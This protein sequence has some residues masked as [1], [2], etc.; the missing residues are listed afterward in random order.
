MGTT[1]I[2]R[3]TPDDSVADL[4]ALL[5]R[6]YAALAGMGLRFVATWQDETITVKRIARGECFVAEVDGRIVGTI[7]FLPSSVTKG[8]PFYDRPDVAGFQQFA[9]EPNFQKSGIGRAL[10][11]RVEER[12]RETGANHLALDTA[13]P[14]VHLIE[15]YFR[16]GYRVIESVQWDATNYTSVV[17]A[18]ELDGS[19]LELPVARKERD[20]KAETP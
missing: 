14:A 13:E 18:K 7:L 9:V 2:R 20:G 3:K 4:T 11:E 10:L 19:R 1:S 16:H 6:A 15:Y 17:M 12:A 8:S 5:H